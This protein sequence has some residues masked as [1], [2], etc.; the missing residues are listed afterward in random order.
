MS[1]QEKKKEEGRVAAPKC[2]PKLYKPYSGR[3][4]AQRGRKNNKK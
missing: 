4:N 3:Q 1:R 2:T